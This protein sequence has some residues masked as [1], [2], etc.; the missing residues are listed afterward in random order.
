VHDGA[1][2]LSGITVL[3]GAESGRVDATSH[4]RG[5][6]APVV[7]HYRE[8]GTEPDPHLKRGTEWKRPLDGGL[9]ANHL[10]IDLARVTAVSVHVDET[11]LEMDEPLVLTAT[12]SHKATV[13]LVDG[14]AERVVTVP[15]GESERTIRRHGGDG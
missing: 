9:A 1:Y 6:A 14:Q 7:E 12:S 3:E 5:Y 10:D 15:A 13:R 2:W 11:D 8:P 4:A